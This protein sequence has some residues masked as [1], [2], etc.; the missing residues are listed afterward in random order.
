MATGS[1][2][3][4][5]AS[6]GSSQWYPCGFSL[7]GCQMGDLTHPFVSRT[8]LELWPRDPRIL[9]V[10]SLC[11][12]SITINTGDPMAESLPLIT[13]SS[14]GPLT[15]VLGVGFRTFGIPS[16]YNII[17]PQAECDF[18]LCQGFCGILTPRGGEKES[19]SPSYSRKGVGVWR[20]GGRESRSAFHCLPLIERS[21]SKAPTQTFLPGLKCTGFLL[22][23]MRYLLG[24]PQ[25]EKSP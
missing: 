25:C 1:V 8:A 19:S 9:Y 24:K 10:W 5:S 23:W 13:G 11:D 3:L 20:R 2:F 17:T 15:G 18:K 6:G 16:L 7:D 12:H 14:R 21:Q 22:S 4:C